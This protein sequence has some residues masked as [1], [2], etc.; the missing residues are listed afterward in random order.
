LYDTVFPGGFTVAGVEKEVAV[1]PRGV[2]QQLEHGHARGH[3]LVLQPELGNVRPHRRT[4]IDAPFL[5]EPHDRG[6]GERLGG[7]PDLE[8]RGP[9]DRQ[10]VVEAGDAVVGVR[11]LAALIDA[12]RDAWDVQP[13]RQRRRLLLD[14]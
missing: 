6:R 5:D 2:V 13:L 7:R 1:P 10:R 4:Q 14:L 12:D 3:A 9:V 11:L 8:Q